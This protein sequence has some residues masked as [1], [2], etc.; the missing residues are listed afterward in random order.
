MVFLF[1]EY[2]LCPVK[3]RRN[4]N[5]GGGHHFKKERDVT[6]PQILRARYYNWLEKKTRVLIAEIGTTAVREARVRVT[7]VSL[8][9]YAGGASAGISENKA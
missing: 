6:K 8:F 9:C 5:V 1:L 7:T 2:V 4:K 3:R